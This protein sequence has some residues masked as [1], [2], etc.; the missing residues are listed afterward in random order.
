M[1]KLCASFA[2]H[3]DM[4][5]APRHGKRIDGTRSAETVAPVVAVPVSSI[6]GG[7]LDYWHSSR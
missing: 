3:I 2:Q 4:T 1:M 6:E 5:L 7:G